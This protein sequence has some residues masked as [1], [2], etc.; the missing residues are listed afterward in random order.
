MKEA[1]SCVAAVGCTS[2]SQF[3]NAVFERP[4]KVSVAPKNAVTMDSWP[5]EGD[6]L[7]EN[8]ATFYRTQTISRRARPRFRKGRVTLIYHIVY[9]ITFTV[10]QQK[11]EKVD[12]YHS[13]GTK[14]QNEINTHKWQHILEVGLI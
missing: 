14:K 11:N 5:V 4:S 9:H 13:I 7:G 2:F 10:G 1:Y 3:L 6:S 8:A 12:L